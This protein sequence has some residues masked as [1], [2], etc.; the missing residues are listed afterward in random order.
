M[1]R[2]VGFDCPLVPGARF[3][4][5]LGPILLGVLGLTGCAHQQ[6]RLQSEEETEHDRYQVATIGEKTQ[7]GNAEAV[8]VSGVGLVEGLEGTGGDIPADGLR[9]M[10][11]NDLRKDESERRVRELLSSP[12]NALV[13]VS[14]VV[15]PGA[16]EKDPID[17]EVTLPRNSKATSLRGGRLRKCRLFN[18]DFAKNLNPNYQGSANLL[19]GHAIAEAQGAVLVG[20]GERGRSRCARAASGRAAAARSISRSRW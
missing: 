13:L 8:Q 4:R 19:L 16:R 3:G 20:L 17:V 14:A 5:L 9:A 12:N 11:Q 15:P 2:R 6:T 7:V 1:Y 18:Y 10:L